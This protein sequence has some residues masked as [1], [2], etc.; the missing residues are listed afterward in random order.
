MNI[1]YTFQPPI[2]LPRMSIGPLKMSRRVTKTDYKALK[3]RGDKVRMS[4]Y[5]VINRSFAYVIII[6][7]ASKYY[8]AN[9]S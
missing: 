4:D 3:Q 5:R 6:I 8:R 1:K 7:V 2:T 9:S